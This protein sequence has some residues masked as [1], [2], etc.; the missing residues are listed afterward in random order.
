[1]A[2]KLKAKHICTNCCE[3]T[4]TC[5]ERCEESIVEL[6]SVDEGRKL[7]PDSD[8]EWLH[9]AVRLDGICP[10]GVTVASSGGE[11]FTVVE[12]NVYRTSSYTRD[13]GHTWR[14]EFEIVR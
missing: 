8:S 4:G 11:R 12:G 14:Y 13:G 1:M 3:V 2:A 5:S 9:G 6:D 7:F 10:G